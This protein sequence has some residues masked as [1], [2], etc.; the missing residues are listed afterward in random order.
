MTE[1]QDLDL[2]ARY[3]V[4]EEHAGLWNRWRG[5]V[6]LERR[7]ARG[8]TYRENAYPGIYSDTGWAYSRDRQRLW[9]RLQRVCDRMDEQRTR[10]M[11][12]LEL[13]A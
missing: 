11:A 5:K 7:G 13:P 4:I 12:R 3:I 9:R 8:G 10:E 2:P 1:V 6:E